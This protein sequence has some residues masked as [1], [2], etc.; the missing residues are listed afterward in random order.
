MFYYL[1]P[2]CSHD[3][4]DCLCRENDNTPLSK[5]LTGEPTKHTGQQIIILQLL[6]IIIIIADIL[7]NYT[8]ANVNYTCVY[9]LMGSRM[10]FENKT[11]QLLTNTPATNTDS[12]RYIHCLEISH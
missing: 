11:M 3:Y 6:I 4:S 2:V 5:L 9:I 1:S 12:Q 8:I 7:N 10:R